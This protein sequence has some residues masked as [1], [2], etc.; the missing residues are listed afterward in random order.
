VRQWRSAPL[1]ES[2]RC[3][4]AT[5]NKL[6]A[7]DDELKAMGRT[8]SWVGEAAEAARAEQKAISDRL[9]DLVA[10]VSAAR[11]AV[12]Q[13]ADATMQ[14]EK[15]VQVIEQYAAANSLVITDTQV[16]DTFMLPCFAQL[17]DRE[18]A[19]AQRQRIVTE[20]VS[21][22]ADVQHK[23]ADVSDD[24]IAALR[25]VL[26]NDLRKL[27]ADSLAEAATDGSDFAVRHEATGPDS[28]LP[29]SKNLVWDPAKG[30][31]DNT[32]EISTSDEVGAGAFGLSAEMIN[33]YGR[34]WSVEIPTGSAPVPEYPRGDALGPTDDLWR[35]QE[36][37]RRPS[38][39][40]V[41][42]GMPGVDPAVPAIPAADD[43][44]LP[45][46]GNQSGF[47][48]TPINPPAWAR[49][50]G[51]ALGVA[52][53]A[54]TIGGAG[55]GQWQQDAALHPGMST[56][57]RIARVATT[58]V[59]EGGSAA[60]GGWGGAWAGAEVGAA[61]GSFA[62]PVGTVVGGVAGGVIG[63]FAGSKA[64]AYLGCEARNVWHHVFG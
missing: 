30:W 57:T 50:A 3:L 34:G 37:V 61:V 7:V 6:V 14:I 46:W 45:G 20:C 24:L 36:L 53:T 11:R 43:V 28:W 54:L 40:L 10:E 26:S 17:A 64:G 4:S 58:A 38:G 35:G 62:G 22:I 2:G 47:S 55:Y 56:E 25:F 29:Q 52:G 39:L 31:V 12:L 23:A 5:L 9:E 51:T 18:A 8:P 44:R 21:M 27:T 42:Q 60:A 32:V 41:P 15:A 59:V 1:E 49:G 19:V 16:T 63:G 48:E 33:R 13:A